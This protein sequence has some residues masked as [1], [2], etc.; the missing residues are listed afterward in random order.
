[1]SSI[2]KLHALPVCHTPS[3]FKLTNNERDKILSLEYVKDG[4]E[5]VNISNNSFILEDIEL[6]RIKTFLN[7]SF[8]WFKDNVLEIKNDFRLTQ[9][10][11][12]VNK[13]FSYHHKH[14]HPN[15][16]FSIVY[17]A[18]IESG[19]LMLDFPYSRIQ[20]RF[21]FSYDVKNWN[22]F[23]SNSWKFKLSTG[24]VLIFPSWLDHYST[25]N[26]VDSDRIII[27]ANYFITGNV[28]D[29]ENVDFIQI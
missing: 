21:N 27:G 22:E 20:E 19:D 7:E 23:N 3:E 25:P 6:S 14:N 9:S 1:M 5:G 18:E 26:Q 11:A 8:L 4:Y 2:F 28:G 10:W 17:Y 16:M 29:T 13:M 24:D 12:T 15:S